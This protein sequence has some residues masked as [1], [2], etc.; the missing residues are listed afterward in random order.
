MYPLALRSTM[1]ATAIQK[2]LRYNSSVFTFKELIL[3][4]REPNTKRLKRRLQY[5][6]QTGAL[7]HIRRGIYAKDKNYDRMELGTKIYTPA[8]VSF[9]TVLFESGIIFQ[10]YKSIFIAS[11][12]T[13]DITCDGQT[14][15]FKQLKRPILVNTSGLID[16]GNYFVATK[17]RA[18]LDTLYLNKNYYFDNLF[19]LDQKKVFELLPLYNNKRMT[20]QVIDHFKRINRDGNSHDN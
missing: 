15:T 8:Y 7:Y 9:E 14:Y 10:Y 3:L 18:F 6:I 5:Y 16:R 11:Y 1:D 12:Q 20:N 13:R 17:E 4:F 2:I 19:P